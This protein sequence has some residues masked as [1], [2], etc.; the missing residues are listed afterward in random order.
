MLKIAL[1]Q[2][3]R[4]EDFNSV[5]SSLSPP[6]DITTIASSTDCKDIKIGIIGAGLAGLSSAFELRKLGFDITIFETKKQH[7]GGRIHTHY[8]DKNKNLYGELGAMRIPV[9]HETTWHY[10]DLFNLQTI[11]FVQTNENAF[12]YIRNKRV[13]NDSKGKNVMKEIY[14]EFNLTPAEKNTSWQK[15][16]DYALGDNLLKIN[17]SIRKELLHIKKQYPILIQS[18]DSLSIR[19]NLKK[20]NLSEGAIELISCIVPFL[21]AF[22]NNSYLENLQED[23]SV[24][25][26]YRYQIV[27]GF[28]NLPLAFYNSL[29][30]KDPKEY[31]NIEK[32]NLGKVTLENGKTVTSIFEN[33]KTNKV[34][35]EYKCENSLEKFSKDFDYII[36]TIPLSSLRN[37]NIYP[38][39]STQ[40]MQAIKEV[41]YSSSQ[42]TLFLCNERFWEK[43]LYDEKIFGGGSSTDLSIQ[44][45]WYPSYDIKSSNKYNNSGVLLASYNLG[46]DAIRLGNLNDKIRFETI[47][48]QVEM[49]HGLPNKYLDSVVTDFKTITWDNVQGILGAFCYFTPN[50]HT[51]FSYVMSKPEYNNKVYFAGE[52]TSNKHGWIQGAVNSGMNAA[53]SI[54]EYCKKI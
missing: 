29:N 11:P 2:A 3:N 40:K 15:L 33:R 39:F 28:N 24:D 4:I 34:I 21:G 37:I 27:G 36:C 49:V 35:L 23:Y 54:A 1:K 5:V 22:Y 8:F 38:M 46:Q 48:R 47:K 26:A 16:I 43:G 41:N 42:K 52:H 45:I 50:Q 44:T 31:T 18:L 19:D 12:I 9:S 7:I 17:P 25:Y 10:I 32:K 20:M 30:S 6:K 14:P 13:R 53:N 51:L